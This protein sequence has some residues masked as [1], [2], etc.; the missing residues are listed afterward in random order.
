MLFHRRNNYLLDVT[1]ATHC[2]A[3]MPIIIS[4]HSALCYI[5]LLSNIQ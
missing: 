5:W 4:T 3:A 1:L 2:H